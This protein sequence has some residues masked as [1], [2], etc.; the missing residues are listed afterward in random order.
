VGVAAKFAQPVDGELD[1]D[2][3]DD[4]DDGPDIAPGVPC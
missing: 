4:E 2:Q 3:V 1:L